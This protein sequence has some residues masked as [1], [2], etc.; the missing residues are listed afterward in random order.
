MLNR[1]AHE[2]RANRETNSHA[3]HVE[4]IIEDET[5]DPEWEAAKEKFIKWHYFWNVWRIEFKMKAFIAFM[6]H[7]YLTLWT[8]IYHEAK[9]RA[10][11]N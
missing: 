9:K 4:Y 1:T 10:F 3:Q 2:I 7:Y 11:L 8:R 5:V 6:E